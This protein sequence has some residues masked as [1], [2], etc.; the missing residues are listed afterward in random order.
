MTPAEIQAAV[1]AA[2]KNGNWLIRADTDGVSPHPEAGGFR[3]APVGE[4]TEAP[5]WNPK[6]RCGGG[7]HGQSPRGSGYIQ[8]AQRLV[9]C[10][11]DGEHVVIE[12]NKV[13]V[14]RARI[15]IENELP[16]GLEI[17]GDLDLS[18]KIGRAHV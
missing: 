10:D 14:R 8:T 7:L 16:T 15:L 13:K 5:D 1:A 18:G 3:W 9:F 11:T 17:P 6:P 12:D 4:W 2:A